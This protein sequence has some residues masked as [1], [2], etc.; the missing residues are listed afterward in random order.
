MGLRFHTFRIRTIPGLS[1]L[2]FKTYAHW[3]RE[4]GKDKEREETNS[5]MIVC[6]SRRGELRPRQSLEYSRGRGQW[7]F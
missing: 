6:L 5:E 1:I 4:K 7:S 3:T 2:K